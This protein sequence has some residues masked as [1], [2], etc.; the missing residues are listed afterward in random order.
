[1][2]Q[3]DAIRSFHQKLLNYMDSYGDDPSCAVTLVLPTG[4]VTITAI[5]LYHVD[6][7]IL[8]ALRKEERECSNNEAYPP[9]P[10]CPQSGLSDH[11]ADDC[12]YCIRLFAG[13]PIPPNLC[14]SHLF[15]KEK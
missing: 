15:L 9:H 4:N 11:L 12:P 2:E 7:V 6:N 3:S 14:W 10:D 8:D 5:E 13:E 1:M